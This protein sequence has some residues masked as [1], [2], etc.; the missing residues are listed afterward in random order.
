MA[1][2]LNDRK[3]RGSL[4]QKVLRRHHVRSDTLV[5]DELGLNHGRY[6]A[7]VAVING[8]LI[9]FEIKSDEDTLARLEEQIRAYDAVFDRSTAVVGR[10][11]VS[12]AMTTLP[13]WWGVMMADLGPRG[14][15]RFKSIRQATRNR[16]VNPFSVAQLLWRDE[17]ETILV[18]RGAPRRLLRQPR[19]ALYK[20]LT[21]V[22]PLADLQEKV[23]DCLRSRRNWRRPV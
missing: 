14:A 16:S 19:A 11:H 17:A 18:E 8:H 3:V 2:R 23:R 5:I 22:L 12:K 6:R 1:S 10:R 15:V 7:D 4:H 13:K 21:S 20:E 9:G